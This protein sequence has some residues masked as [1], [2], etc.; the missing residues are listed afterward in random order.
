[1]RYTS[2]MAAPISFRPTAE[3]LK[4]L[5]VLESAGLSRA[6]AIRTALLAAANRYRLLPALRAEVERL[7]ND[8]ID[9]A[10]IKEIREF[11]SDGIDGLPE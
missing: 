5:A 11:F 9:R 4:N 6:E 1:M 2:E 3:D 7:R 10:A 8:P